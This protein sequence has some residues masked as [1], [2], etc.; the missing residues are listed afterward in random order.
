MW[1]A[2]YSDA[3][4]HDDS[5]AS[6]AFFVSKKN[7]ELRL[8][9][10]YRGLTSQ[11]Q[12]DKFAL[13]LIDTLLDKRSKS[14]VFSRLDL[15]NGF[16]QIRM[17]DGDIFKIAF[18]RPGGLFERTSMQRIQENSFHLNLTKSSFDAECIEFL[19]FQISPAGV[20]PLAANVS[21]IL[22]MPSTFSSRRAVR[23]FLATR[24]V[25]SIFDRSLPTRI[26]YDASSSGIGAVLMQQHA[27]SWYPT[28]FLSR[29]LSKLETN[30]PVTDKEWLAVIQALT[31]W[32]HYLQERFCFRSDH[33]PLLS[34]LSKTSTQLQ[35]RPPQVQD[36]F[37]LRDDNVYF[38]KTRLYVP[39][40]PVLRA[41]LIAKHHDSCYAGHLWRYRRTECPSRG[42]YCPSLSQNVE[43]YAKSCDICIRKK[44]T[45]HPVLPTSSPIAAPSRWQTGSLNVL[46]PLI[47]DS[48]ATP[49]SNTYI[50]VFVA[51]LT[52]MLRLAAC[53]QQLSA[54][55]AATLF[56]EHAFRHHGLPE[57]LLSCQGPHFTSTFWKHVFC[58]LQTEV[59][60]TTSD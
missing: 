45:R 6:P 55:K 33:K 41:R 25:L 44:V 12:P 59:I 9:V 16:Y 3:E 53:P 22:P 47:T 1:T 8:V 26:T 38:C 7:G 40:H 60:R 19:G 21:S 32:R 28:Q 5:S 54:G 30:Y 11:E 14:K 37:S 39:K 17:A 57:R 4:F 48:P 24:P 56:I 36:K 52:K 49:G 34:L 2:V 13:P 23:R 51:K 10:D 27:D 29:T 46:G 58:A 31:K 42:F 43:T 15:R 20:Q 50:L 18:S 35:D